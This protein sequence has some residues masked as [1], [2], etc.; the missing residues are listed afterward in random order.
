MRPIRIATP[1]RSETSEGGL[2][3]YLVHWN[4][5]HDGFR[6]RDAIL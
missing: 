3:E 5:R 2:G 1:A 4:V 6:S